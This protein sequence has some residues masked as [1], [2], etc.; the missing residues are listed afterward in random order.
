MIDLK[1]YKGFVLLKNDNSKE[2]QA[3]MI[4]CALQKIPYIRLNKKDKSR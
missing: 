3:I 2:A 1:G 4:S